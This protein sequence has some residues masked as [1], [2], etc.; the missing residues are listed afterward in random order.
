MTK[1]Y[2]RNWNKTKTPKEALDYAVS[3][4]FNVYAIV[5]NTGKPFLYFTCSVEQAQGEATELITGNKSSGYAYIYNISLL[6]PKKYICY[7]AC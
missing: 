5:R 7:G 2:V 3:N 4:G 6:E 1:T